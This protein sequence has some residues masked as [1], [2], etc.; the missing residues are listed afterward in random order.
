ME[1]LGKR[2]TIEAYTAQ[3]PMKIRGAA[4]E[5]KTSGGKEVKR[6]SDS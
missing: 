1:R 3:P 4:I 6:L 5:S 2:D